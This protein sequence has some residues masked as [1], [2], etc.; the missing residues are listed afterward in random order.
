MEHLRS[1]PLFDPLPPPE[2]I[3]SIETLEDVRQFRQDS[4]QWDA[5]HEGRCTTSQAASALGFL[6]PQAGVELNIPLS[7]RRGGQSAYYRLS[8]NKEPLRTVPGMN[9]VLCEGASAMRTSPWSTARPQKGP[10]WI[11]LRHAGAN[12]YP[13]AAKYLVK[14]TPDERRNRRSKAEHYAANGFF[15]SVR[16]SW[17]TAQEATSLLTALNYFHKVEPG[18]RLKEVGMCGAGLRCNQTQNVLIG[19]SPDGILCYPNGTMEAL[20]VKD[21]CPFVPARDS[22]KNDDFKS[23]IRFSTNARSRSNYSATVHSSAHD[24]NVVHWTRVSVRRHGPADCHEWCS[25]FAPPS[26]RCMVG[27]ND[28]LVEPLSE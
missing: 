22:N 3:A 28:V 13:F 19:A 11:V 18:V 21:H 26:G 15:R 2:T 1:H 9:A 6:E 20:E 12:Q 23:M 27:R 17:G 8:S 5:L 4:W 14:I 16:T 24:G 10:F 25:P 7:W